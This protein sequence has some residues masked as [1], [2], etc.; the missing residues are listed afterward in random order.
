[1]V[2]LVSK[3]LLYRDWEMHATTGTMDNVTI[4]QNCTILGTVYA[5]NIKGDVYTA[6]TSAFN[7]ISNKRVDGQYTWEVLKIRGAISGS[8]GCFP[9]PAV[10]HA[11][12]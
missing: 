5:E 2:M 11:Q 9:V 10:V 7:P 12:Q 8:T 6:Q 1:M 3:M 4:N